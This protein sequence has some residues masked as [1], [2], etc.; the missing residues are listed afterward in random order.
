MF[1]AEELHKQITEAK[2]VSTWDSF[3]GFDIC[4]ACFCAVYPLLS[5]YHAEVCS[6]IKLMEETLY[7]SI[8]Q[9]D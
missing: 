4:P 9:E 3:H 1:N 7:N 6:A 5:Q 8:D 2:D